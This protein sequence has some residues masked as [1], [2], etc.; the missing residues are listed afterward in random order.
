MRWGE[1]DMSWA[2]MNRICPASLEEVTLRLRMLQ[3]VGRRTFSH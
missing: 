3:R 1:L 2:S